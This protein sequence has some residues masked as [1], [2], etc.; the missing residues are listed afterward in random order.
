MFVGMQL[1][2]VQSGNA[3]YFLRA[4]LTSCFQLR[5][6][7]LMSELELMN[8]NY[9]NYA[10]KIV[11]NLNLTGAR[12]YNKDSSDFSESSGAMSLLKS[13]CAFAFHHVPF[14]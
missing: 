9:Y 12:L 6:L 14:V 1:S 7:V 5:V 8:N 10:E 2:S 3:P 13:I 11:V 4:V